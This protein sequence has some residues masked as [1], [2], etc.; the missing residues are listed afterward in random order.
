M[1]FATLLLSLVGL[2]AIAATTPFPGAGYNDVDEYLG[3]DIATQGAEMMQSIFKG[4]SGSRTASDECS[5][6]KLQAQHSFHNW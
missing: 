3:A 6:K 5:G 1:K 2:A 4:C